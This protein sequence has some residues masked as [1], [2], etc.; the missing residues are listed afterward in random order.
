MSGILRGVEGEITG[1]FSGCFGILYL[2]SLGLS[3]VATQFS[4]LETIFI[5]KII[6]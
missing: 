3:N 1:V 2:I 4:R 5:I 6:P